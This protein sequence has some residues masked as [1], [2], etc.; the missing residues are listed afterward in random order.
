MRPLILLAILTPSARACFDETRGGCF[1]AGFV[2]NLSTAD[3]S[4]DCGAHGE[5]YGRAV[6][7]P[8]AEVY[9]GADRRAYVDSD[10]S[11]DASA[12][13]G[14]HGEAYGRAVAET[15]P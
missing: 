9:A 15:V 14:A 10:S 13:C 11:A 1:T 7:A 4:A 2:D 8:D 6:A 3:A 12:D 5:A